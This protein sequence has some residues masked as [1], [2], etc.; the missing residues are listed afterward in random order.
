MSLSFKAVYLPLLRSAAQK[1]RRGKKEN[2]ADLGIDSILTKSRTSVFLLLFLWSSH[3]RLT[4]A[5]YI[6]P[7][8]SDWRLL[9]RDMMKSCSVATLI[10]PPSLANTEDWISEVLIC[11]RLPACVCVCTRL[12]TRVMKID[13]CVHGCWDPRVCVYVCASA[14]WRGETHGE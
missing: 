6:R 13:L 5:S 4:N 9:V 10:R 2:A 7:I 3:P 14:A 11:A 8:M 12:H 1:D